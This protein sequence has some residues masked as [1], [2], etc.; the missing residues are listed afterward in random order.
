MGSKARSLAVGAPT[1]TRHAGKEAAMRP[2]CDVQ[3]EKGW[4]LRRGRMAITLCH[5]ERAYPCRRRNPFG[6]RLIAIVLLLISV[7]QPHADSLSKPTLLN[8]QFEQRLSAEIPLNLSFT[9]EHGAPAQLRDY[10]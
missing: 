10:F 6:M 3:R 5:S 2:G 7:G 8:L 9:N 4:C 1:S